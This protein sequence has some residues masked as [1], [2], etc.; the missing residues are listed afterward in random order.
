LAPYVRVWK[1]VAW[2]IA[3]ATVGVGSYFTCRAITSRRELRETVFWIDQTY[4]RHEGGENYGF[5]HGNE[6]HYLENS[7]LHTEEVTQE[8]HETFSYKGGCNIVLHHETVP[9]GVFKSVHR[10]YDDSFSLCDVDPDSIKISK[11]DFRKDFFNCTDAEQVELFKLDCSS[12]EIEFHTRNEVPNIKEDSMTTFAELTGAEHI[13]ES[14][15]Q[16]SKEWFIV[17][18]AAYAERLAKAFRHAVELCGGKPSKF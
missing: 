12:A 11:F 13:A 4:N 14:H 7:T 3:V 1:R 18:N 16:R 5:G 9:V 15:S 2:G 17:D 6:T 10:T 8:F